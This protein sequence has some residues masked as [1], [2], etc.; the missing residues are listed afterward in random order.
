M[1]SQCPGISVDRHKLK[2]IEEKATEDLQRR[3]LTRRNGQSVTN[4]IHR[5]I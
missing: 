4:A 5:G 2:E 3:D 1:E